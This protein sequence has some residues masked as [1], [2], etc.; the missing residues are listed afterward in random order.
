MVL[1]WFYMVFS[2]VLYGFTIWF[3]M[4]LQWFNMVLL[5]FNMVLQW[6]NM[7]LLCFYMALIGF[8]WFNMVSV[9]DDHGIILGYSWIYPLQNEH[10][11]GKS[12]CL[13]G[14]VSLNCH[15]Q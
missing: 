4:V 10:N 5:W 8:L 12:P 3:N 9:W 7:V 15:V 1:L 14:K 13:M 2:M 11:H 6:F